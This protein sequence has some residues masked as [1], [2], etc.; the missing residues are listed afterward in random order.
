ALLRPIRGVLQ[1]R[2]DGP[3]VPTATITPVGPTL[4]PVPPV[5]AGA[6]PKTATLRPIKGRLTPVEKTPVR[7]LQP[8]EEEDED[9][10]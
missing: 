3:Q 1:P 2:D 7:T 10:D 5:S 9:Q 6:K 8:Q 4:M